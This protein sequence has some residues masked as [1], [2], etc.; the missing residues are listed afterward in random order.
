MIFEMIKTAR[1]SLRKITPEVMLYVYNHFSDDELLD[2]FAIE[3]AEALEK[4][5]WKFRNGQ[6]TYNKKWQ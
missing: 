5:K 4:E 6:T 3:T 1:L 2:F